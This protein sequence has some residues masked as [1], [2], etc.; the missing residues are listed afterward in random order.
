[1]YI[2]FEKEPYE[3]G[4][5]LRK[6]PIIIPIPLT[7]ATPDQTDR[8]RNRG[9]KNAKKNEGKLGGGGEPWAP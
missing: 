2:S 3:R 1:L 8:E 9:N 6:R 5:I 7:V 4:N